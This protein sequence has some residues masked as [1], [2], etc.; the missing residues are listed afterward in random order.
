ML[1]VEF[2]QSTSSVSFF[3]SGVPT[4]VGTFAESGGDSVF[5]LDRSGGGVQLYSKSSLAVVWSAEA[6]HLFSWCCVVC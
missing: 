4:G 3:L 2:G 6:V 5:A 1:F